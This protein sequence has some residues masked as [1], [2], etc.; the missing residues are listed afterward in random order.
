MRS[1]LDCGIGLYY[2]PGFLLYIY[3]PGDVVVSEVYFPI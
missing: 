3:I 2:S 1:L